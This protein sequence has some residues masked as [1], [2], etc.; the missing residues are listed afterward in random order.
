MNSLYDMDEPPPTRDE[1][2]AVKQNARKR[3]NLWRKRGL[4]ST[5]ALLLSCFIVYL[6]LEGAPLHAYWESFGKYLLLLSMALLL[7][8]LYCTLLWF[9]AWRALCDLNKGLL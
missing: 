6:F 8:F 1:I 7:V 9:A 2:E 5:A 4:Y 3:L